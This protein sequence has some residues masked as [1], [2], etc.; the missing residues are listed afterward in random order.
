MSRL[1]NKSFTQVTFR[2]IL[3]PVPFR[4]D[5]IVNFDLTEAIGK[6]QQSL[7]NNLPGTS[8]VLARYC[9][10]HVINATITVNVNCKDS[11][12]FCILSTTKQ[13]LVVW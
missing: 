12:T 11:V 5:N 13:N 7:H 1:N 4:Y 6:S 9:D 10:H 8:Y 2:T 3:R